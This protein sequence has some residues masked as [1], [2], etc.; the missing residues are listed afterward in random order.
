[1][2]P[3]SINNTKQTHLSIVG[4]L[5]CLFSSIAYQAHAAPETWFDPSI[6]ITG[7]SAAGRFGTSLSCSAP[8]VNTAN[9]SL[10]A[11]GA[12]DES[13]AAGAVY[14]YDPDTPASH[15]QKLTSES[16]GAGKAFGSAVTFLK[17]FNGDLI[18]ELAITEPNTAG[19]NSIIWVYQSTNTNPPY[20]RC[21]SWSLTGAGWGKRMLAA[22][23][24]NPIMAATLVV[25]EPNDTGF[26][27][28]HVYLPLAGSPTCEVHEWSTLNTL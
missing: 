21:G 14:I 24:Y 11:I 2:S 13:S 6:S 5:I 10:I 4:L 26:N 25:S 28:L 19:N 22:Q 12:P 15:I 1:M 27:A 8:S 3:I 23:R 16:A 18:D 20:S 17:D 9:R 7:P